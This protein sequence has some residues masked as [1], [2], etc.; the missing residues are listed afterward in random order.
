MIAREKARHRSALLTYLNSKKNSF[1]DKLNQIIQ[2]EHMMASIEAVSN[3]MD[4]EIQFL[5]VFGLLD[6]G[7]TLIRECHVNKYKFNLST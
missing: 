5:G 7:R 3:F 4:K 6:M 2:I 1:D